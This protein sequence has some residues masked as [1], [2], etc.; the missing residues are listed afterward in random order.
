MPAS[1]ADIQDEDPPS[2]PTR[3]PQA[4]RSGTARAGRRVRLMVDVNQRLDVLGN[5][6]QARC[7]RTW[8]SSGMKSRCWPTISL[9][10]PRFPKKS[11][12]RWRPARTNYTRYEFRELIERRAAP[13]PDA[14]RLPRQRLQRNAAHRPARRSARGRR[15]A[16]RGARALAAR[17]RRARQRLFSSSSSTGRRPTCSRKCRR[18]RTATS[19]SRAD[20]AMAWHSLRA[21]SRSTAAAHNR[22]RTPPF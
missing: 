12:F 19:R 8:T 18:A 1:A 16:A 9:P 17:R 11:A 5:I 3:E 20:L 4:G 14:R 22:S 6:R 7:S 10:A 13:L 15:F 2:G 21:L